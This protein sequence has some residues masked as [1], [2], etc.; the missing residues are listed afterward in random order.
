MVGRLWPPISEKGGGLRMETFRFAHPAAFVLLA[1]PLLWWLYYRRYAPKNN[2]AALQF[3]DIRLMSG[4]PIS[5]RV[6]LRYLPD[7]LRYGALLLLIIGL[8]RPQTG[9]ARETLRGRGLDMVLAVDISGSMGT[10]DFEPSNRLTAAKAVMNNFITQ[11]HF[12]RIGLVVF[13]RDAFQQA[14]PTLDHDILL[15]LLEQIQL[16]P[17]IGLEDGTA[18]GEG[19]AAAANML[20]ESEAIS[21][22]IILL[23]DGVEEGG[24]IAPVTAAEAV[25]ALGIQVYTIGMGQRETIDEETLRQVAQATGGAY[26][27]AGDT[28]ALQHTYEIIDSLEKTDVE[29]VRLIDWQDVVA[30]WL[31]LGL[32]LLVCE[33]LLR[34][35]VLEI[36]P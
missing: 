32:V 36:L 29:Q 18:I 21:K 20:R 15:V 6:R 35:T 13:A 19:L 3:S 11:R 16:A 12:D 31:I 34:L 23:T 7:A 5:L 30:P 4:L 14:P 9:F 27:Y 26:F 8:A 22:V 25:G 24:V 17:D 33:Y 10:A 28:E 1:V 2:H